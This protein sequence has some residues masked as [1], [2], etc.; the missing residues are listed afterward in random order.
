MNISSSGKIL[1]IQHFFH[2][3]Q[4]SIVV[5]KQKKEKKT[6]GEKKHAYIHTKKK[7][8]NK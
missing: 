4:H 5:D 2:L 1:S 8:K 3:S 7:K 6:K